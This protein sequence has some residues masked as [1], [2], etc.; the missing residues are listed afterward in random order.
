MPPIT[1]G[2][3]TQDYTEQDLLLIQ[4]RVVAN[5]QRAEAHKLE[6]WQWL[7]EEQ[8]KLG[9]DAIAFLDEHGQQ[10]QPTLYLEHWSTYPE[11]VRTICIV[12]V[13]QLTHAVVLVHRSLPTTYVRASS[14]YPRRDLG[15][16]RGRCRGRGLR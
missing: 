5:K 1:S 4:P 6:T 10:T 11:G 14:S 8:C 2:M 13:A 15:H 12:M 16:G 3:I 9:L 7:R